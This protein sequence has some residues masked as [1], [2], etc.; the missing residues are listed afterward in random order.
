MSKYLVTGGAGFIGSHIVEELLKRG[1]EAVVLDDLST[2]NRDNLP[3][4]VSLIEGDICDTS[5]LAK[6]INGVDGV[7][8]MAAVASVQASIK[9]W[10]ETHRTN[11]TGTIQVFDLAKDEKTPVVFA[12]SAA[13]YGNNQNLPLDEN[14][15][16]HPLSAY[17]ADKYGCELHGYVASHVHKVP[18]IGCRFFNVYGPRQDPSS[19]YSGVISIFSD[20][21]GSKKPITIFGDG[22]QTRDFIFVKD[23]VETLFAAMDKLQNGPIT[24]DVFNVCTNR[25]TNL[26]QLANTLMDITGNKVNVQHNLPREGDIRESLGNAKKMNTTLGVSADTKLEDGLRTII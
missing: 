11:L 21:I 25:S 4:S 7:F 12:S 23:V 19:P 15:K 14:E 6:A 24:H 26:L 1:D 3:P 9:A 20:Q 22:K 18:N 8:H 17:G 5:A 13:I 16:A 2:G 10:I